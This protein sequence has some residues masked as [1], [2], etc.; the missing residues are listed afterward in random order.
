MVR[1]AVV[2]G[3]SSGIGYALTETLL[4]EGYQVLG[5]GRMLK[6]SKS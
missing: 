2:T 1:A 5:V 6:N 3:A 4:R